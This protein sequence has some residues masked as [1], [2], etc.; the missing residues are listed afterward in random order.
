MTLPVALLA[1][2]MATRMGSLTRSLPKS[3]LDVAGQPFILR[4]LHYLRHQ[5]VSSAVLCIGHLGT[6]IEDV[7]GD[8]SALGLDVRYSRDGALPLGTGGAILRA[9]PL[10]GN[11]FFVM[12]GDSFLPIDYRQVEEAYRRSARPALMT[13]LRNEDRWDR[14]NVVYFAGR[15]NNYDKRE[16]TPDMHHIDYGLGV[17]SASVFADSPANAA[18]DLAD[19]YHDLA[20]R[21][22]LAG[23]EVADRFYEIGSQAGL[24]DAIT[25]FANS[26]PP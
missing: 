22:L 18:F 5:G 1:G 15:I 21:E 23:M 16:H 26:A 9:L 11:E 12:Y 3:L 8:G 10:L 24:S 6:Q 7:V 20:R 25:Y 2:G 14:S 13:V 4:Q 19:L 17:L